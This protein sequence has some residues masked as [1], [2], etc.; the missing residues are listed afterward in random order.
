MR[1]TEKKEEGKI[2]SFALVCCYRK[3]FLIIRLMFRDDFLEG[4]IHKGINGDNEK[5][6]L[7]HIKNV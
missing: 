7:V 1:G 2:V 5:Q 4:D 3:E 6:I